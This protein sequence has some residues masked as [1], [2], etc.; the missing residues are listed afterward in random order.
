MLHHLR[1]PGNKDFIVRP[2][3]A[4]RT[5]NGKT[6]VRVGLRQQVDHLLAGRLAAGKL[7]G[8]AMRAEIFLDIAMVVIIE[9]ER[10]RRDMDEI[11]H[12]PCHRPFA[13]TA[14]G[15]DVSEIES[16][17]GAPGRGKAGAV[18]TGYRYRRA[19]L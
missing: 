14:G 3:Q 18:A 12:P 1:Q 19:S 2:E 13:Q 15:A 17:L 10:W 8:E 7:V 6:G 11:A 9:I 16:L 5:Q 4:L